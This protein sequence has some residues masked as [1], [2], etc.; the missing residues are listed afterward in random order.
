ME[1]FLKKISHVDADLCDNGSMQSDTG[2]KRTRGRPRTAGIDK[3]ASGAQALQRGLVLLSDLAK[4]ETATLT[5]L[6]LRTGMPPSTVHRLLTTLQAHGYTEFDEAT[7][8]WMVGV[9]AFRTGNSYVRRINLVDAARDVMKG[10]VTS[11]GETANLAVPD[12]GEVVFVSQVE[13]SNP[14]RAFFSAG[15]RTPMHA[16]GIG[17]AILASLDRR[18]VERLLQGTGL[19]EFTASTVTSP[20][21]LFASLAD[22]G[23]RGWSF[24]DEERHVGMRCVA[25]A[26][27]DDNGNAVGG[28]SVSGPSSR[29]SS[30]TVGEFGP[31]VLRAAREITARIGGH[32]PGQ[33]V[34][35]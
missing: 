23:A 7:N 8:F 1:K 16:S 11:T 17:K 19:P 25:A 20:D 28:I 33:P 32:E 14:V 31:I 27:F 15:T 2:H 30:G 18:S 10:L 4:Q 5:E 24:D 13:S 21:A 12:G 9:E 3:G 35:S 26:I 6:A 29:F 22:I 34:E